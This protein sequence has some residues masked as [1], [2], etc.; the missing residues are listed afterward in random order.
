MDL[1]LRFD[2]LTNLIWN[3][4]GLDFEIKHSNLSRRG[5]WVETSKTLK[6]GISRW[7]IQDP[8]GRNFEMRHLRPSGLNF[9]MRHLRPS[10]RNFEMSIQ[11]PW[12]RN[13]EMRHLRPL[14]LEFRDETSKALE[15]GISRWDIW[16]LWGGNF[17][18]SEIYSGKIW[19]SKFAPHYLET[20]EMLEDHSFR[21]RVD[22]Y[23]R[24]LI[25]M[26]TSKWLYFRCQLSSI[27]TCRGALVPK[28]PLGFWNCLFSWIWRWLLA[29]PLMVI[30]R[31]FFHSIS[32]FTFFCKKNLFESLAPFFFPHLLHWVMS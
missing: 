27:I 4:L 21:L 12:I 30:N 31:T 23:G 26:S 3:S 14:R 10:G 19:I 29:V 18:F 24:A 16:D 6:V 9:E 25:H 17:K 5:F 11:G 22:S 7:D 32:Y 15:V 20:V 1:P 8:R 28:A 13:F 2:S